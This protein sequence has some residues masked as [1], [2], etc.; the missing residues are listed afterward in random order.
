MNPTASSSELGWDP[1]LLF[2][3]STVLIS[4]CGAGYWCS[5]MGCNL[6]PAVKF[7]VPRALT[8]LAMDMMVPPEGLAARNGCDELG[9][10]SR[11]VL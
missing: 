2:S 5:T 6:P 10:A 7:H 3:S 9:A 8:T 11:P 1:R 4:C